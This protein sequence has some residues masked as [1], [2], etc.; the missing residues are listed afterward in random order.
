VVRADD[1][2]ASASVRMAHPAHPPPEA[3]PTGIGPFAGK[4]F[5]GRIVHEK[6]IRAGLPNALS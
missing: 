1:A 4:E 3:E 5:H 6:G 2:R